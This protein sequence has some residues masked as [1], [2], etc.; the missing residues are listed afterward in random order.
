[1]AEPE[2]RWNTHEFPA[3]YCCC[4]IRVAS[5]IVQDRFRRLAIMLEDLQDGQLPTLVEVDWSGMIVDCAS[6]MGLVA[7]GLPAYPDG[8]DKPECRTLAA[9]WHAAN[10]QG[11]LARSAAVWRNGIALGWAG[12]HRQW[13]E[14]AIFVRNARRSPRLVR[15][16]RDLNWLGGA[17]AKRV[18]PR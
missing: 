5:E 9:T 14:L 4:S 17:G 10:L 7:A 16:R 12:S 11:V 18:R 2:N 13:S 15:R 6:P 8:V 1:M 3:L